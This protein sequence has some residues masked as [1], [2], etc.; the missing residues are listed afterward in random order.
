VIDLEELRGGSDFP[1]D[2]IDLAE[3]L[4][5]SCAAPALALGLEAEL[6]AE[7]L[8]EITATLP[9]ALRTRALASELTGGELLSAGLRKALDEL[10]IGEALV[11]SGH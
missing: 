3:E 10:G 11:R 7:F 6:P 1:A 8:D 2:L 9:K 5:A 4:T